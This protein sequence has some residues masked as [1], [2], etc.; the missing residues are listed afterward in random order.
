MKLRDWS[1]PVCKQPNLADESFCINCGC[2]YDASM[3]ELTERKASY[4]GPVL[5]N[6]PNDLPDQKP[7]RPLFSDPWWNEELGLLGVSLAIFPV[8]AIAGAIAVVGGALVSGRTLRIE[9][10]LYGALILGFGMAVRN[11]FRPFGLGPKYG[12]RKGVV[13]AFVGIFLVALLVVFY[14]L[15]YQ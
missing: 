8:A 11:L 2:P 10:P 15:A 3:K 1:C 9:E 12:T 7:K 6:P 5:A 4:K 13:L 14:A